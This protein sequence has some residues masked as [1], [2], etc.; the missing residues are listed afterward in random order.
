MYVCPPLIIISL[1]PLKFVHF[2]HRLWCYKNAVPF[3]NCFLFGARNYLQMFKEISVRITVRKYV[4]VESI[5][6][7]SAEYFVY[8]L[9]WKFPGSPAF[10]IRQPLYNRLFYTH[11]TPFS[12]V[13][14][15]SNAGPLYE[16]QPSVSGI[17]DPLLQSLRASTINALSGT[18]RRRL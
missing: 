3:R 10:F 17:R 9:M 15:S 4:L 18:K 12:C 5:E 16:Q 14:Y 8:I 13:T 1:L 2:F 6:P 7:K 11:T